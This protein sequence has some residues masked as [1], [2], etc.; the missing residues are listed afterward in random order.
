MSTPSVKWKK[1]WNVTGPAPQPRHGHRAVVIKDL[2][3]IFGGGNEGIMDELHVFNTGKFT[4]APNNIVKSNYYKEKCC[5]V[6][7]RILFKE[8][9]GCSFNIPL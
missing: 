2:I 9:N 6:R 4:M 8:C 1:V 5:K 3:I 7:R